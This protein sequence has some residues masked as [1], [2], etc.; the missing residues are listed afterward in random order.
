MWYKI[1]LNQLYKIIKCYKTHHKWK[2]INEKVLTYNKKF[3]SYLKCLINV[4]NNYIKYEGSKC[5]KMKGHF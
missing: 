3:W 5:I 1:G 2:S 4:R